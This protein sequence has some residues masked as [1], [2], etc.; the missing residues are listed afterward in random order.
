VKAVIVGGGAHAPADRRYLADAD[1]VIAA[2]GGA[3]WLEAVGVSP[4]RLVGDL[5]SVDPV[6]ADRL[7]ATGVPVDRHPE[8]KDASDLELAVAS[9]AAAGADELVVLGALGGALDHLAANLLLL[10]SATTAERRTSLVHDGTRAAM[11]VGPG[12]RS[13]DAP[14]GSRVT[15]LPVGEAVEG[16]TT[17]GLR[18]ALNDARLEPGSSRG[19]ANVVIGPPAEVSLDAG[20]LLI[21]EI[22]PGGALGGGEGER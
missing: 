17:S 5:D 1:L 4:H 10:G 16:V 15:L 9:A 13:I 21:I 20:R 11:V 14:P 18:W 6:L 22:E 19:L 2:D 7:D 3:D 12:R 8:D